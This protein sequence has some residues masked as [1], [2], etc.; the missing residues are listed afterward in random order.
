MDAAMAGD[1][2]RGSFSDAAMLCTNVHGIGWGR[3]GL[4]VWM[5][6]G[7]CGIA[8]GMQK[9]ELL[10]QPLSLSSSPNDQPKSWSKLL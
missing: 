8:E 3:A 7:M 5:V 6:G 10:S 9:L 1:T 4:V 2:P